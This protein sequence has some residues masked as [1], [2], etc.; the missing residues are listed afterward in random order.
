MTMMNYTEDDKWV[1]TRRLEQ[2]LLPPE[3]L[4]RFTI[5]PLPPTVYIP[6]QNKTLVCNKYK[7]SMRK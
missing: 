3:S 2:F 5:L 4:P 7:Y 6:L 1:N